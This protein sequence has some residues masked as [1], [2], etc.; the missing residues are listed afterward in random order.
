MPPHP[1]GVIPNGGWGGRKR[2][3]V[4]RGALPWHEPLSRGKGSGRLRGQ[5]QAQTKLF[6]RE[7]DRKGR[8][9]ETETPQEGVSTTQRGKERVEP[10]AAAR[11]E[12]Q[13]DSVSTYNLTPQTSG[14]LNK[15]S[16]PP[17]QSD[18]SV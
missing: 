16:V 11:L 15:V 5:P 7:E 14:F 4:R 12:S 17:N 13:G 2:G 1:Q 18:V 10:D 6:S 3:L 8:G 9:W